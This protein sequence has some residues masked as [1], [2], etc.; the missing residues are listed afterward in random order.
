ME[1]GIYKSKFTAVFFSENH[2]VSFPGLFRFFPGFFSYR[3]EF[4]PIQKMKTVT[5][6]EYLYSMHIF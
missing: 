5:N 3:L 6:F 1:S 2:R 4:L